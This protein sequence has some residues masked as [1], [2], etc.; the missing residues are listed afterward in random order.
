M[1]GLTLSMLVRWSQGNYNYSMSHEICTWFWCALFCCA[2]IIRSNYWYS[3]GWF[4]ATGAIIG[5]W[6]TWWRHQME[7]FC[8][9]LAICAGNSPVPG[10]FPAQRPVTR[11]FNVFFYLRLN[12]RLSKESSGWWLEMLPR[13]LLG[14][15][16]QTMYKL[17]T[18]PCTSW[19]GCS[20]Q[21]LV[22]YQKHISNFVKMSYSFSVSV[23]LLYTNISPKYKMRLLV[24]RLQDISKG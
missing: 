24:T 16:N 18:K 23:S 3:A 7:T 9:L 10:E 6:S 15:S 21:K 14:H 4:T 11:S 12:K 19:F 2:Y 13:P 20:T 17:W 22:L 1:M 5:L 8:T